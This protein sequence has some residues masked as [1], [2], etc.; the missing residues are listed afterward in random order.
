MTLSVVGVQSSGK[1]SLLNTMFGLQ[2]PVSASRSTKGAYMQLI[3]V[4]EESFDFDY[5]LVFDSDSLPLL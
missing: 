5:I 3:T 4:D 2:F 1:S